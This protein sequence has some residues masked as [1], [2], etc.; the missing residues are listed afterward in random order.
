MPKPEIDNPLQPS[1]AHLERIRVRA[2][3]LWEHDGKPEGHAAEYWE[4]A[5]ELDALEN[6]E[7]TMLPNPLVAHPGRDPDAPLVEE[8]ALEENLGEFPG[9]TSDQ[10]DSMHTPESREIAREFREG[11]R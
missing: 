9:L 7:P 5:R 11:E 10:G 3:H 1:E 6:N 2:Y 8:A 4:R